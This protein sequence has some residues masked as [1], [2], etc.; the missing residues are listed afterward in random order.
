MAIQFA[1]LCDDSDHFGS[2]PGAGSSIG[3]VRVSV[4]A[5]GLDAIGPA[6]PD[7]PAADDDSVAPEPAGAAMLAAAVFVVLEATAARKRF[8]VSSLLVT[9]PLMIS[10][11][12]TP[13]FL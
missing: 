8:A 12:R 2:A 4:G 5:C 9:V 3:K 10:D 6:V 13:L 1:V 11:A 7:D